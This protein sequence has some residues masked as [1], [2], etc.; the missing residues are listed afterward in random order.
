MPSAVFCPCCLSWRQE[1]YRE[2][3][4]C[5]PWAAP[6]GSPL[7]LRYPPPRADSPRCGFVLSLPLSFPAS[8]LLLGHQTWRWHK[9]GW[10]VEDGG[11][12]RLTGSL[13]SPV[14]N[15]RKGVFVI[16]SHWEW[17]QPVALWRNR[18]QHLTPGIHDAEHFTVDF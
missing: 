4:I 10:G 17:G 8:L 15:V 9:A 7:W 6:V 3:V 11:S 2:R 13:V 12:W 1:R 5:Q 16:F 14:V 18:V